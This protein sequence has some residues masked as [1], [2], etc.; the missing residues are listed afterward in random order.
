VSLKHAQFSENHR[1][2]SVIVSR[3]LETIQPFDKYNQGNVLVELGYN[4]HSKKKE[5]EAQ[6]TTIRLQ[7]RNQKNPNE[8]LA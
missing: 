3:R 7:K 5:D 6:F 2:L 4:F 8:V 1:L